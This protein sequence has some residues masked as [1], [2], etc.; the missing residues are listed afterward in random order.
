MTAVAERAEHVPR[1][2]RAAW[3]TVIV[4]MPFQQADRPS[5][6][7]G[8]LKA[9]GEAHGFPVRT[10][11]ANLDFA[12][13]IGLDHY[14]LLADHRGRQLGDWLFS[15]EAFGD[16]APDP[17][18]KLLAEFEA[19]LSYLAGE[20]GSA[21]ERLLAIREH[22]VP[23]FLDALVDE[24]DGVRVVGFSST[25]QQNAASFALARRLKRR[26]PDLVTVFGGANFDGEMGLEL[27]RSVE[28]VDFAV[29]GEGD[30]AFPRLLDALAS[31]AEPSGI[32]GVARRAGDR[33]VATPP[34]A[35]HA[36]L[37]EL[38]APD[39]GEYFDR[40]ARLGLPTEHIAI[41][42]E[43]ARGCW[44]GAKHHCTFCGLNGTT[45]RFRA[46]S[47]ERVLGE[48]DQQ[49][50]RYR[51]FR[52]EAVDNI[53]DPAYLKRLF[54]AITAG[55]RDYQIFYEVKAN[56]TRAQLKLLAEAGVARLQPGLESLSSHVLRLMDK[57]VRA[58]QNVNVLRWARYYGMI[59]D[60]NILW[61]FPGETAEDYAAQAAV[62]P[63]LVHLQP[64]ASADRVW[65]ERFSPLFTRPD[66]FPMRWREPEPSYRRVYP[67][68]VDIE[69]VAYFFDYELEQA[70][71]PA[72]YEALGDAV[73]RWSAAW[74]ADPPPVLVY[75]SAPG[76]L[77]IYDGRHRDSRGTYTF[78]D[79]LAEIYL[80]CVD[81]PRTAMAVHR[82]LG[83]GVPVS[84][85]ANA[86]RR[87]GERGL[88]FLDDGLAVALALPATPG[89]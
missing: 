58:A 46:K 35:P 26:Y 2:S 84:V 44:W 61:G 52:F 23:A 29:I 25:F 3:P 50:R 77:Q 62:V 33:V 88:M 16:A 79:T 22:D 34:A 42:F 1:A 51:S 32:P 80:A 49:A 55:R 74:R 15:V 53:L 36:R 64:P 41:P 8:L 65:L 24:F 37:D 87:F 59:V 17:D 6:Q 39:Y 57:G 67:A 40:A 20:A 31:G 89:R 4:C 28:C 38:P 75:R 45:M 54:P 14:R 5:I 27:V 18:G 7:L 68:T 72:A 63:H 86:F 19:E 60:W 9:I 73:T 83:L 82:E 47:P 78:R 10:L 71:D 56:L 81:R 70:L 66:R 13:R 12:V 48:L 85:V 43:S 21:R 76:F 69:R 30:T 11:H